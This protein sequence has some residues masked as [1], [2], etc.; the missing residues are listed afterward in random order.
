MVDTENLESQSLDAEGTTDLAGSTPA[1]LRRIEIFGWGLFVVW[2]TGLIA[3]AVIEP[4]PYR[5]GWMLVLELAFIG[6]RAVSIAHGVAEGFSHTYLMFQCGLQDIV[7]SCIAYPWIVRVYRGVS[8]AGWF[9]RILK[10]LHT[11]MEDN[12][13]LIEPFGGVGLWLFVFFPFWSTGVVNGALLGFLLGMR[14]RVNLGIVISAHVASTIAFLFFFN[15]IADMME[16]TEEGWLKWLPWIVIGT[17][18]GLLI[19]QKLVKRL[20]NRNQSAP[21]EGE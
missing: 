20:R 13:K 16:S 6:G 8:N 12:R 3:W 15:A 18:L 14:T 21:S 11:T 1:S 10:G 17:L 9:G 7:Y 2:L 19:I 5:R 4:D